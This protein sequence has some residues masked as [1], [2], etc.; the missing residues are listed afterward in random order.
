M[1]TDRIGLYNRALLLLGE[2]QL[3]S[4]TENR[5]PRRYL[6]VAW[7]G[8]ALNK[9]LIMGQWK[10]AQ[11]TVRMDAD[12]VL[13]TLFGYAYAFGAPDDL[14]RT[15]RVCT[16]EFFNSPLEQYE[17]ENGIYYASF[18][19]FYLSYVSND[20][21]FGG[22]MSRW[23]PNFCTFVEH[24]LALQILGALTGNRT[25]KDALEKDTTRRLLRAQSSDAMEQATKY[26]PAGSWVR[27]R[28]GNRPGWDRGNTGR[29]IG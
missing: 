16:D 20:M 17:E 25:D 21:A 6:D 8:D 3:A 22:D 13:E 1:G 23:P 24:W 5:A 29:L 7:N 19:P 28:A 2:R 4:L 9:L 26:P 15:T 27:A 14:V 18:S 12:P 11:R 10:F